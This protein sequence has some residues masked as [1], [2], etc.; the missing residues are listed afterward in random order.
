MERMASETDTDESCRP[1]D[2]NEQVQTKHTGQNGQKRLQSLRK[3]PKYVLFLTLKDYF[4]RNRS[5][6]AVALAHARRRA[7]SHSLSCK[8]TNKEIKILL[9]KPANIWKKRTKWRK[10]SVSDK[11]SRSQDAEGGERG[12]SVRCNERPMQNVPKK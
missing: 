2:D 6:L 8:M 11:G 9:C 5:K 3:Y 10:G 7:R 4:R 12:I 1:H